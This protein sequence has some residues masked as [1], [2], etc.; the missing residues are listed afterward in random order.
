MTTYTIKS[1][2]H[3]PSSLLA[4]VSRMLFDE[5]PRAF[6]ENTVTGE[7]YPTYGHV[8]F[9][10]V[11]DITLHRAERHA[12]IVHMLCTAEGVVVTVRDDAEPELITVVHRCVSFA[13][14]RG[15]KR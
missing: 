11:G 10:T 8:P 5:W 12:D 7:V 2:R 15:R 14:E 4:L 1:A 9:A 6:A 13:E 3:A